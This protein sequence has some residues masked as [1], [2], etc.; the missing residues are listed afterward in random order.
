M[1]VARQTITLSEDFDP[2]S[3]LF[4]SHDDVEY[5]FV[6]F[7]NRE[8][9]LEVYRISKTADV[10][11]FG[12]IGLEMFEDFE[13][14]QEVSCRGENIFVRVIA[15]D[16]LFAHTALYR[17]TFQDRYLEKV[18]EIRGSLER[19][20]IVLKQHG[21]AEIYLLEL[22]WDG[23][24]KSKTR[25][26]TFE[27]GHY[28]STR[29]EAG[30]R[31]PYTGRGIAIESVVKGFVIVCSFLSPRFA[32]VTTEEGERRHHYLVDFIKMEI[33]KKI[34]TDFHSI[35]AFDGENMV[36]YISDGMESIVVRDLKSDLT[37]NVASVV[38][39]WEPEI[40]GEL[41]LFHSEEF[42]DV[43]ILSVTNPATMSML[44]NSGLRLFSEDEL[45]SI[46]AQALYIVQE[47]LAK[48][49][50]SRTR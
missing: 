50:R 34:T 14:V 44:A 15:F 32:Q 6:F 4:S 5:P 25:I 41:V 30:L 20:Q 49:S 10:T 37:L 21:D 9:H 16:D 12:V 27:D 36:A 2:A 19:N 46:G 13:K 1:E 38:G 42:R 18:A 29:Y 3:I 35:I 40:S 8:T 11:P 45:D 22:Y 33:V 43:H 26:D 48:D 23:G 24:E 7:V 39:T 28:R 47:K 31:D 17:C